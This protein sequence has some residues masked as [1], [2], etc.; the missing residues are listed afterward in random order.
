MC[1]TLTLASSAWPSSFFAKLPLANCA[2]ISHSV[3]LQWE[4]AH[5]QS[6]LWCFIPRVLLFKGDVILGE[7]FAATQAYYA[8]FF[9]FQF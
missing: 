7:K 6:I 2:Q 5:P 9:Y 1:A 3:M 4:S 8:F